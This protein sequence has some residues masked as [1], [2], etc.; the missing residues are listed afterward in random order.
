MLVG[1]SL[2]ADDR[3][4]YEVVSSVEMGLRRVF[5]GARIDAGDTGVVGSGIA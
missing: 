3:R 2:R 5:E 1:S 4:E